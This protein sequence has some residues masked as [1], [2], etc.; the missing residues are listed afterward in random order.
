MM[1]YAHG[2]DMTPRYRRWDETTNSWGAVRSASAVSGTIQHMV[3]RFAPSREEAILATVDSTGDIRVQIWN[4]LTWGATTLLSNVGTV[5]DGQRG[6]DIAYETSGGRA[7]IVFNNANAADPA[8]RIWDGATLSAATSIDIPTTAAPLWVRLAANPLSAS[9]EISMITIDVNIDVYGMRWTGSAWDNMGVAAVWDATGSIATRESIAVA[10][11]Q[12]S[13]RAMFIWGGGLAT[14]QFFRIWNGS[15][16]TAN[17]LLDIPAAGGLCQWI[18]LVPRPNSNELMYGC[19]D[20]GSDLSTRRWSGTAWDAA[21]AHPEHSGAV[22]QIATRTFDIAWETHSGRVG[23]AWI[24]FGAGTG[25]SRREWT[26]TAWN[27]ITTFGDDT[28]IIRLEAQPISGTFFAMIFEDASSATDDILEQRLVDGGTAWSDSFTVWGGPTVE[29]TFEPFDIAIQY[30]APPPAF[31]QSA[32][33]WFNNLDSTD[34]GMPL[35]AQNTAATLGSPGMTFR[36]RMLLRIDGNQLTISGQ[37]FRLQFAQRGTDNLCDTAFSGETYID[38]TAATIIAYND[39]PAPADGVALTA[40]INDPTHGADIIVNQTYE[41]LNNFTN[42][43]AAILVSQNGKWDFALRDNGAPANTVYCFRA[44]RADGT[45]LNTYA[46][47]PEIITAAPVV[48]TLTFTISDNTIGFGPLISGATRFATGGLGGSATEVEAHNLTASTNAS[49]G[50]VISVAGTT[51][52]FGAHTITPIGGINTASAPGT[53]QFGIRAT[54]TGGTGI[55]SA[56]YAAAGF[57][58]DTVAFPDEFASAPGATA[59][60]TFSVRY[61]ANI[62]PLTEPGRYTANL[63][64]TITGRF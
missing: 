57:A 23:R 46:V 59:L 10:Y 62:A 2:T 47:I 58:L 56:P 50:Y 49:S 4:G 36:L 43:V 38:V 34:V 9:N 8:F 6:V 19:Q 7:I 51:L 22:E 61:L 44:I 18:R 45:F 41:E 20:A 15:T 28:A 39:N 52:T 13:G 32:Y 29:V 17:T 1:V 33:R 37:N 24:I 54:A 40:N 53:E 14:D 5:N 27:P 16:L 64:Y 63:I 48:E 30:F 55:V 21:A 26:G 25:V 11:E 12:I 42:S 60:T 31:N 35:E 3:L